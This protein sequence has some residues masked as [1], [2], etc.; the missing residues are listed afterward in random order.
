[1]LVPIQ[2][3][4]L[5]D[6]PFVERIWHAQS[7]YTGDFTSIAMSHW[8]M[9]VTRL[10]GKMI[11]TVRGPETRPRDLGCPE[12]GEWLGIRFKHGT[13]IP[14]LLPSTLVD[15]DV[16]LPNATETSFWLNGSAWDF[17][18][19]DNAEQFVRRLVRD[20][21]VAND[22]IVDATLRGELRDVSPRTARRHFVRA[23]GLT[24][25]S[26]HQIERAR[27]ATILLEEGMPIAD[28]I[29]EAGYFDQPHLTRSLKRYMDRTP[30]QVAGAKDSLPLSF[31]YK[32]VPPA[33]GEALFEEQSDE[34]HNR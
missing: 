15:S 22:P 12:E 19:Y 13:F 11:L 8:E 16:N 32:T 26:A 3:D 24:P 25:Q 17:P 27:Y 33:L 4:R 1:M 28:V 21:V 30:A 31:L 14:Q 20:G 23:T 2:E 18:D 6:S 7:E 5:S 9:V 34:K 29:Y 10:R